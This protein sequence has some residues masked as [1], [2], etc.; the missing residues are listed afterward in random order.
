MKISNS[1]INENYSEGS[2]KAD[3][4][5]SSL[6]KIKHKKWELYI[7]SRIVHILNDPEIEF[8]CQQLVLR[9]NDSRALADLYFPQFNICLEINERDSHSKDKEKAL[10]KVRN[11]EIIKALGAELFK[12]ENFTDEDEKINDASL[13]KIHAEVDDF[14]KILKNRKESLIIKNEFQPWSIVKKFDPTPYIR[15]GYLD[16]DENPSFR[17]ITDALRC[18]GYSGGLYQKATWKAAD[19]EQHIVWFPSFLPHKTWRNQL[20]DDQNTIIEELIDPSLVQKHSE[21][22]EQV[23]RYTFAKTKNRLGE[24]AYRF[25]GE[26]RYQHEDRSAYTMKRRYLLTRKRISI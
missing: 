9:G 13:D 5:A 25:L 2:K 7:I 11:T 1:E 15:K 4:I 26:F 22:P 20:L 21:P 6:S 23:Y 24:T 19:W 14:V 16:A 12:I 3:Y 10:D 17:Y 18:F 8:V